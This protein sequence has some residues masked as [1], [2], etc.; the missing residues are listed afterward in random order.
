MK[1][2]ISICSVVLL[3]ALVL[4]ARSASAES[5]WGHYRCRDGVI[6]IGDAEPD[7]LRRCGEPA[8]TE[9]LGEEDRLVRDVERPYGTGYGGRGHV[10]RWIV[11]HVVSTRWE[12]SSDSQRTSID[13]KFENGRVVSITT[14][15]K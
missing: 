6:S 7:V 8:S 4:P 5:Q 1:V 9:F 12:Y 14:R 11:E 10:P 3:F 15:R 13:I 2:L